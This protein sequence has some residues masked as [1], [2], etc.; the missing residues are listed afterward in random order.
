MTYK[1]LYQSDAMT[2]MYTPL[3]K[4]LDGVNAKKFDKHENLK[5]L[6]Q[7]DARTNHLLVKIPQEIK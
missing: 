3:V 6:Y 2:P 5:D 1:C 4:T 7:C